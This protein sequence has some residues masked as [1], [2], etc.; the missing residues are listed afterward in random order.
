[1]KAVLKNGDEVEI[2]NRFKP[3]Q[4]EKSEVLSYMVWEG[5]D[6]KWKQILFED[7][8]YLTDSVFNLKSH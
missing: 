4:V 8:E 1:M 5:T 2:G 6:I 3:S 7:I